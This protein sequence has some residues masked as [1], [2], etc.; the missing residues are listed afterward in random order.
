LEIFAKFR[1]EKQKRN[2]KRIRKREKGPGEPFRPT[3]E[4]QPAAQLL[5]PEAVPSSL[6]HA[7]NRPH[8]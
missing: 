5:K 6:S 8:P 1:K 3:P 7:D 4:N 2:S